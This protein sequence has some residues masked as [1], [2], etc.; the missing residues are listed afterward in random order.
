MAREHKGPR[1]IVDGRF[2][3]LSKDGEIQ[4]DKPLVQI[5][6]APGDPE[7]GSE[8]F[9]FAGKHDPPQMIDADSIVE[10][11]PDTATGRGKAGI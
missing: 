6:L 2:Y 10:L 8:R 1:A 7:D 9:V 5:D 3:P 4:L 11:E